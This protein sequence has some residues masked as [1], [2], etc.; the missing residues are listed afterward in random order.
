M[1]S[2]V[3]KCNC[4][5]DALSPGQTGVSTRYYEAV[6]YN[7][8]L[9]TNNKDVLNFPFYNPQYMKIYQNPE[10]IDWNWVKE[11]VP[12]DYHYDKRFSPLRLLE[13]VEQRKKIIRGV[14]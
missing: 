10:D 14:E 4:I 2:E 5:L 7:K 6:C 11:R 8:K 3:L 9:L 12:I 1:I 13:W